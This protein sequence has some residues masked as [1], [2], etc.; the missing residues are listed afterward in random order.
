VKRFALFCGQ[1]VSLGFPSLA[2]FARELHPLNDVPT[3]ASGE[4]KVGRQAVNQA[5]AQLLLRDMVAPP[6]GKG[7]RDG[8][9]ASCSRWPLVNTR[10]IY[11]H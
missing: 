8:V 7:K 9:A 10:I 11:R 6:A 3:F 2:R 4:A 1:S 5:L